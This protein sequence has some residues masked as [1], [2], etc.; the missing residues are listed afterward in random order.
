MNGVQQMMI[1]VDV[2]GKKFATD[3]LQLQYIRSCGSTFFV[4]VSY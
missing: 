3:Y 4:S 1:I 2:A